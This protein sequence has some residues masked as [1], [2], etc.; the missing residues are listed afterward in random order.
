MSFCARFYLS[1]LETMVFAFRND[2]INKNTTILKEKS[3]GKLQLD[4]E[5]LFDP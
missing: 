2:N 4:S 3:Q 1:F 5:A